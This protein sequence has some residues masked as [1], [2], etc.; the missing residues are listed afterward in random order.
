MKK[1]LLLMAVVAMMCMGGM[2]Q[3]ALT[4]FTTEAS[5]TPN[6]APGYYLED[7]NYTPWLALSSN[8]LGSPKTF[9]GNGWT[10]Q[11]S[12][13]GSGGLDGSPTPG[14]GG[15]VSTY[16]VGSPI[17]VAFTGL[18]PKAIGGIFWTTDING[19]FVSGGTVTL[20]VVGGGT[21]TYTDTSNYP[22][23]TGFLS[24]TPITS[25]AITPGGGLWATMDHVYVGNTAAVPEP[26]SI[27]LGIMGLGSV[28]GFRKLRRN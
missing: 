3:A 19:A 7:F 16:Y 14:S 6:L 9:S 8:G 1:L 17:N 12:T 15:A 18:L 13:T 23:F 22:G 11:L 27:L 28:A 24:D 2:A 26:M 5:F 25:M 4:W 10:Y 20:T 21:Y